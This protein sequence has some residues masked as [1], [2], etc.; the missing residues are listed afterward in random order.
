M[1]N[2]GY[3]VDNENSSEF[4]KEGDT[5]ESNMVCSYQGIVPCGER[6]VDVKGGEVRLQESLTL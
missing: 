6:G 1:N 5:E 3:L 4:A 2:Y